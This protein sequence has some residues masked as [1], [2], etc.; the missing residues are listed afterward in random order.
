MP[1]KTHH[2]AGEADLSTPLSNEGCLNT[3]P[4]CHRSQYSLSLLIFIQRWDILWQGN[5]SSARSFQAGSRRHWVGVTDLRYAGGQPRRANGVLWLQSQRKYC[6]LIKH[7]KIHTGKGSALADCH[8]SAVGLQIKCPVLHLHPW[9][10]EELVPGPRNNTGAQDNQDLSSK[11]SMKTNRVDMR[12]TLCIQRKQ[13][14]GT[15]L[16]D[17]SGPEGDRHSGKMGVIFLQVSL[18]LALW[19]LSLHSC[20]TQEYESEILRN[21]E[22]EG[23]GGE[24]TSFYQGNYHHSNY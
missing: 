20:K 16:S 15:G 3:W 9:Q 6:D 12:Q 2:A 11:Q 5:H 7:R 21:G 23:K 13:N 1:N 22:E 18:C 10:S 17:Y 19:S 8:V 4:D 14:I 24:R